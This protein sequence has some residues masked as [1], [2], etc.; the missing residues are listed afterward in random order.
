MG[1][2]RSRHAFTRQQNSVDPARCRGQPKN[3]SPGYSP[4][5]SLRQY[6]CDSRRGNTCSVQWRKS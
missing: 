1:A 5:Y 4:G 6:F 3:I 2:T